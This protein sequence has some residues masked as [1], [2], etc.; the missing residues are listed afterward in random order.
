VAVLTLRKVS[1]L[2]DSASTY[3]LMLPAV[4]RPASENLPAAGFGWFDVD[5]VFG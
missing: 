3:C 1:P 5:I 4:R 2:A